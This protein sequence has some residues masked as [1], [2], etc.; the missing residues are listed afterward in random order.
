MGGNVFATGWA[1][2]GVWEHDVVEDGARR[3]DRA[4]TRREGP[5]AASRNHIVVKDREE[6]RMI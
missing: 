4:S 6:D 3:G 1:D 5:A 2:G